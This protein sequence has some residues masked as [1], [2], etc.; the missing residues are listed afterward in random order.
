MK[1]MIFPLPDGRKLLIRP[2]ALE[3][4][5][6]YRQLQKKDTEA[7]G[8]LIGRILFESNDFI[9]D[10]VSEPMFSD[11]RKRAYFKRK[12]AA[13][14]AYFDT[15]WAASD[16]RCFYLGE[17]HTHPETIP[18]P[19]IV[20]MTDWNRIMNLSFESD[21]LFF[22]IVGTQGTKVWGADRDN[23]RIIELRGEKNYE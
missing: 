4:M 12:P 3:K 9:I 20:D 8:I 14:Q 11:I 5:R 17:W 16:G 1:E 19:S 18:H 10:N 13:H 15:E 6:K 2:E 21:Y 22:V 23:E 7:G